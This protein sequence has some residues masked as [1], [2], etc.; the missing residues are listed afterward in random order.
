MEY[1]AWTTEDIVDVFNVGVEEQIHLR[2]ELPRFDRCFGWVYR[3]RKKTNAVIYT[4]VNRTI[5]KPT[6]SQLKQLLTV[7]LETNRSFW[8]QLR[9]VPTFRHGGEKPQCQPCG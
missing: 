4:T 2:Y 6:G 9:Q 5:P 3:G 8:N 1:A 7:D